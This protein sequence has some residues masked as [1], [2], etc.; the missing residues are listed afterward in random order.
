MGKEE[1]MELEK[2][3]RQ[4]AEIDR[5]LVILRGRNHLNC[6]VCGTNHPPK[7]GDPPISDVEQKHH[8]DGHPFA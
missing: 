5:K 6:R 4:I 2:L 1:R 8:D 3:S 7:P